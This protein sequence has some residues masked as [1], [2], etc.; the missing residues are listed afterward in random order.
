MSA[1]IPM[2]TRNQTALFELRQIA[3]MSDDDDLLDLLDSY[4]DEL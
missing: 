2:A 3:M 4:G 1:G